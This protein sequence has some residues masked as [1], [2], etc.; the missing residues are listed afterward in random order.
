MTTLASAALCLALRGVEVFPLAAGAKGAARRIARLPR[1][2]PRSRRSTYPL[3]AISRRRTSAPRPAQGRGSGF[4]MSI[5][6]T[7]VLLGL[8]QLEAPSMV[9]YRRR[10]RP[11][12]RA[13]GGICTGA[14]H[15][16]SRSGAAR[17]A[18]AL[19][20][21][22]SAWAAQRS[23]RHLSL[24]MGVATPGCGPAPVPSRRRRRG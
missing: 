4:L 22:C 1:R 2:E 6:N 9:R 17:V 21:M 24:P 15:P 13:G 5:C 7:T 23:C 14:C 3:G 8:A 11:Q 12:R 20:S 19:V 18:L 10:S 16:D